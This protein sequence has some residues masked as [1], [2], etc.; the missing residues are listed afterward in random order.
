M[1][2][3]STEASG[4]AV[5]VPHAPSSRRSLLAKVGIVT[6]GVGVAVLRRPEQAAAGRCRL[7]QLTPP[8]GAAA[9]MMKP[10]GAVSPSVAGGAANIDNTA[11]SG[12]G[13][14]LYS[15]RGADALG[16]LLVVNQANAANPQHAVRMAQRRGRARRFDLPQ[17]G[18]RWRRFDRGGTR[19]RL[20]QPARHDGRCAGP[21][22][23]PRDRQDHPPKAGQS[24]PECRRPVARAGRRRDRPQGIFIG[25]DA[26]NVTTGHLLNVRNGGQGT[27]RLILTADGQLQLAIQ[28]PGGGLLMGTDASLYRAAPATLGTDGALLATT[29]G[30]SDATSQARIYV[31]D[32][33]LVIEWTDGSST[34]YTTIRSTAPARTPPPRRRRPTPRLHRR[35]RMSS[36]HER[37]R[38]QARRRPTPR[39]HRCKSCRTISRSS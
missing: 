21:G 28:G 5:D 26:G 32:R 14:V 19:R 20:D 38:H 6:A 1:N 33:K 17:P 30:L 2:P 9:V 35:G 11:S 37:P 3:K 39:R 10:T 29:F 24:R 8:A 25:N 34:L 22:G 16:R 12:A 13:M 36:S 23:R 7:Y 15:D 4:V 31:R 18:R 27:E